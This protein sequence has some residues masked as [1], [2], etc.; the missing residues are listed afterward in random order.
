MMSRSSTPVLFPLAA[1]SLCI[2]ADTTPPGVALR[3]ITMLLLF[4]RC[5]LEQ[6]RVLIAE[7]GPP[8]L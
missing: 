1:E 8:D 5:R 4:L 2:C 7:R 3:A 6:D